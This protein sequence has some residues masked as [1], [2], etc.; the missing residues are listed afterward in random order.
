MACIWHVNKRHWKLERLDDQMLKKTNETGQDKNIHYPN[1]ILSFSVDILTLTVGINWHDYQLNTHLAWHTDAG[2]KQ[3]IKEIVFNLIE[4]SKW[5][6]RKKK[7][8]T[9]QIN[10]SGLFCK[11]KND[12]GSLTI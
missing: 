8:R 1:P 11:K 4:S 5:Q 6:H 3:D 12:V 7:E 9:R 10:L 2:K